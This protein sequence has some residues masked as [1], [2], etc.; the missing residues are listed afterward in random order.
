LVTTLFAVVVHHAKAFIL[1]L[2][3]PNLL[4]LFYFYSFYDTI[5]N[6]QIG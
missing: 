5:H 2:R 3:M 1:I 4:D 6:A